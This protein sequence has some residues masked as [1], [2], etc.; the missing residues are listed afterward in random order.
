VTA[1]Q[2]T[3]VSVL[4]KAVGEFELLAKLTIAVK[5]WTD[6]RTHL[7]ITDQET[8]MTQTRRFKFPIQALEW[9]KGHIQADA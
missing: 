9:V 4:L 1:T 2:R 8:H 6:G 7:E 5:T 3:T